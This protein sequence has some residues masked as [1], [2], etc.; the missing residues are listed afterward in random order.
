MKFSPQDLKKTY[1]G[2]Y[3]NWIFA[4]NNKGEWVGR[5][6]KEQGIIVS[7]IDETGKEVPVL[8]VRKPVSTGGIGLNI[9][10]QAITALFKKK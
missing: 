7:K 8:E 5:N 4:Q 1:P 3:D 2:K 10:S 6:K 9:W